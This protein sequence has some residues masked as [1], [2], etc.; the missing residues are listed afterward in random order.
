MIDR[1]KLNVREIKRTIARLMTIKAQL[2]KKQEAK[3]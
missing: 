3:Q 1:L 2:N